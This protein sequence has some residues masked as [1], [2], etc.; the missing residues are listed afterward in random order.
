MFIVGTKMNKED[1]QYGNVCNQECKKPCDYYDVYESIIIMQLF[2]TKLNKRVYRREHGHKDCE[3]P[4]NF[5]DIS[6][7][8]T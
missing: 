4:P 8:V 3:D 6:L 1:C 7:L 5:N 2:K